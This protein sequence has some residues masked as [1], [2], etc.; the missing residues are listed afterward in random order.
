MQQ[1]TKEDRN[2]F[3]SIFSKMGSNWHYFAISIVS[4]LILAFI[5]NSYAPRKYRVTAKILIPNSRSFVNAAEVLPGFEQLMGIKNFQNELQMLRSFPI[6]RNTVSKLNIEVSYYVKDKL[7]K[8]ETY[9][10]SPFTVVYDKQR[11]QPANIYFEIDIIDKD[12]F[13]IRA[14]GENVPFYSYSEDKEVFKK[15]EFAMERTCKFG[16]NIES[17]LYTFKILLMSGQ[18]IAELQSNTYYFKF[19]NIDDLAMEIRNSMDI[20]PA[21]TNSSV[22]TVNFE[23]NNLTKAVDFLQAWCHEFINNSLERKNDVAKTTLEYIDSQLSEVSDSLKTSEKVLQEYR[24]SH[25]VVDLT[26][27]VSSA[28]AQLQE[29]ETQE[30][31]L[32]VQNKY[33][34]YINEYFTLNKDISDLVAPSSMGIADPAL[35]TMVQELIVMNNQRKGLLDKSQ[36]NNPQLKDLNIKIDNTKSTI[37]E[38]IKY[39]LHTSEIALNDVRTRLQRLRADV[40][41]M[42]LT[43]RE[44]VGIERKFKLN[45]TTYNFLLQK[46]VDAHIAKSANVP[47]SQIV[48]PARPVDKDP[49]WPNKKM[50]YI[51]AFVLGLILPFTYFSTKELLN[52][53]IADIG[54]IKKYSDYPIIGKITENHHKDISAFTRP[55]SEIAE[56]FRTLRTSLIYFGKYKNPR[57]ISVNSSISG[58]GKSFIALNLGIAYANY[59][60]KTIVVDFDMRKPDLNKRL[61]I[62]DQIGLSSYLSDSCTLDD[63]IVKTQYENLYVIPA[64]PIPPN[65]LEFISS[66]KNIMLCNLLREQFDY[67]IFDTPPQGLVSDALIL[68]NSVDVNLFVTRINYTPKT[69]FSESIKNLKQNEI[70]NIEIVCNAVPSTKS[71]YGAYYKNN[72]GEKVKK[73]KSIKNAARS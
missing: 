30:A 70:N 52:N 32:D 14:K 48:E 49:I 35:N 16:E 33:Y 19:N 53:N 15:D 36:Q 11:P 26:T 8:R 27:Q 43:E 57:V 7:F 20:K 24:T 18:D 3:N 2:D 60:K 39:G 46:R 40:N 41:Q 67:I 71:K 73:S 50:N 42:P 59:N 55:Q 51:I 68:S 31:N 25:N 54:D 28:Y 66:D 23:L 6:V 64:G 56:S 17:E 47:D 1:L 45:E 10:N 61:N 22:A 37:S 34:T 63:I 5:F 62:P 69:F 38:N 4:L 44:L 58:E 72:D 65:P 13:K 12:R 29:L 21:A 9:K